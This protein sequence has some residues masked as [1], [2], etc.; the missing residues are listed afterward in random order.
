MTWGEIKMIYSILSSTEEESDIAINLPY[1]LPPPLPGTLQTPSNVKNPSRDGGRIS[2]TLPV[3]ALKTKPRWGQKTRDTSLSDEAARA[4][5]A[6]ERR[7]RHQELL[8]KRKNLAKSG[9]D[10]FNLDDESPGFEDCE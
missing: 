10:Y 9:M 3:S 2:I 4:Q 5:L 8:E 7:K 1:L 6:E